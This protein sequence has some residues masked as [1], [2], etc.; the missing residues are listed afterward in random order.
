MVIFAKGL[1]QHAKIKT[2]SDA[3]M[4][5]SLGVRL[6]FGGHLQGVEAKKLAKNVE[7]IQTRHTLGKLATRHC[8]HSNPKL[9]LEA[10][11]V[12]SINL[13]V[14]PS[15]HGP[16]DR[17]DALAFFHSLFC[18][19]RDKC[20]MFDLIQRSTNLRSKIANLVVDNNKHQAPTLSTRIAII[21][22]LDDF[23]VLI[24][25]AKEFRTYVLIRWLALL[26]DKMGKSVGNKIA[27]LILK[28][29]ED[30][31]KSKIDAKNECE[32]ALKTAF[33]FLCG[34]DL[35][36]SKKEKSRSPSL[37]LALVFN[38]M[39]KALVAGIAEQI[40]A[41]ISKIPDANL[42]C[43]AARVVQWQMENNV[44]E[45]ALALLR[46]FVHARQEHLLAE[47]TAKGALPLLLQ[48]CKPST[49]KGAFRIVRFLLLGCQHTSRTFR[50]NIPI[51]SFIAE[52]LIKLAPKPSNSAKKSKLSHNSSSKVEEDTKKLQFI[53]GGD[54]K[55]FSRDFCEMCYCLMFQHSGYP[56]EY[57]PLTEKLTQ[58]MPQRPEEK[59]ML[60]IL[61]SFSWSSDTVIDRSDGDSVLVPVADHSA[62]VPPGLTN[63]GNTCYMNSVLQ[64]LY[65]S[66]EYRTYVMKSLSNEKLTQ[67]FNNRV[68]I[69]LG[70][71]FAHQHLSHRMAI[72][73]RSFLNHLPQMFRNGLQQ[74]ASEFLKYVLDN[75]QI[76]SEHKKIIGK[77]PPDAPFEGQLYSQIK[78]LTCGGVS[79]KWERF[80]ELTV[81]LANAKDSDSVQLVDLLK[82]HFSPERLSG[83]NAYRCST[84]NKRV[85]ADKSLRISKPPEHLIVNLKRHRY[86]AATGISKVMAEVKYPQILKVHTESAEERYG[87]YAA[88]I[89]SGRSFQYGHYYLIGQPS[90]IFQSK[91]EKQ[92]W[93]LY[94]DSSVT[95][96]SLE[97]LENIRAQ[98]PGD[99]P[100]VLFY[101]RL[102]NSD[103][104]DKDSNAMEVEETQEAQGVKAE[105]LRKIENKS[106]IEIKLHRGRLTRMLKVPGKLVQSVSRDNARYVS[107]QKTAKN[108]Q[109]ASST[110]NFSGVKTYRA[111][112]AMYRPH[113]FLP[114]IHPGRK[115]QGY[116][117]AKTEKGDEYTDPDFE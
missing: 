2:A 39:P 81:S 90:D 15:L 62:S 14:P 3:S 32:L 42:L 37:C 73:P 34:S 56:L 116:P 27:S 74:D 31:S 33:A 10:T 44:S 86:S 60:K 11:S 102:G 58:L 94:N 92:T 91:E 22:L 46:G 43:A 107:E 109:K 79:E 103:K 100:Y 6:F 66:D 38:K 85:E 29:F 97:I 96:V 52:E 76:S 98:F 21:R 50:D 115:A 112:N 16:S 26:P 77:D 106:A 30:P 65:L 63:L 9:A 104:I 47:I 1:A 53:A 82:E 20:K 113:V 61:K 54:L 70:N 12:K 17:S 64:A 110:Y 48:L 87:L 78:T 24:P 95:K 7:F 93:H 51:L 40:S 80:S 45:W 68:C 59:E 23:P 75:T 55:D 89:H 84:C 36:P 88:V 83:D 49:R 101:R 72:T 5:I 57:I 114:G 67:I 41:V 111:L 18:S 108:T 8:F 4:L 71:L 19:L 105:N 25:S 117:E 13:L 99:V 69:E 35:G 28:V